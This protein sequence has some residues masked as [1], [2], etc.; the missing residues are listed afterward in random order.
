MINAT[1]Y[2]LSTFLSFSKP[3]TFLL[4]ATFTFLLAA[5]IAQ[6]IN[7]IVFEQYT[8]LKAQLAAMDPAELGQM[9]GTDPDYL[10][11]LEI[12]RPLSVFGS[13]LVV[14]NGL[15][16]F[17]LSVPVAGQFAQEY[18][19]GTLA[20]TFLIAPRRIAVFSS[21]VFFALVYVAASVG[22]MWLIIAVAGKWL[23]APIGLPVESS[24]GVFSPVYPAGGEFAWNLA[25]SND[26]WRVLLY[27][28]GYML[29][30]VSISILTKSQTLGVLVPV[31]Y[32]G[33]VETAAAASDSLNVA[34]VKSGDW[35]ADPFRFFLQG[36]AWINQDAE[37]PLAGAIY[38]GVIL[39]LL[40][41][42]LWAFVR[43]DAKV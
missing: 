41:L 22:I 20:T 10:K 18:R 9:T 11:T 37:Y 19:F 30:V 1:R 13:Q 43:R 8:A 12:F 3:V 27:V 33:F 5:E 24:T 38:F 31:F 29:I 26:W 25:S 32:L 4:L 2:G 39:I 42:S 17:F 28:L 23:P 40:A 7:A 21:K 35:I 36:H 16:L 6:V 14:L 34:G 15:V